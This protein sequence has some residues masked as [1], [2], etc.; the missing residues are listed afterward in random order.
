M[1]AKD[2]IH[3]SFVVQLASRSFFPVLHPPEP[4]SESPPQL[5]QIVS[6]GPVGLPTASPSVCLNTLSTIGQRLP[7]AG[8]PGDSNAKGAS[9]RSNPVSESRR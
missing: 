3:F 4:V 8:N 1:A 5:I 9:L 2:V 7:A 6:V